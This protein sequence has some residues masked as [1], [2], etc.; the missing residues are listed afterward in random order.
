MS[1]VLGIISGVGLLIALYLFLNNAKQT[2]QIIDSVAG[3]S[4]KGITVLQG[5]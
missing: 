2:T 5:R 4:I 1:R 3:N